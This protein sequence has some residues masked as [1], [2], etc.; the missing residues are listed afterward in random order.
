[1]RGI[2][3]MANPIYLDPILDHVLRILIAL[4]AE[5]YVLRDR[6]RILEELLEAR[7]VL[8]R[9]E[10]ERYV[11]DDPG[12]YRREREAFMIRLFDTLAPDSESAAPL[13]P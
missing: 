3:M 10:I 1:M 2:T 5:V 8:R 7:G 13:S 4:A 12:A 6:Q 9:E 11:P